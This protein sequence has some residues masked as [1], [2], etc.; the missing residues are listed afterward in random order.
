MLLQNLFIFV[1]GKYFGF[2]DSFG[3]DV[4]QQWFN[5]Y[6]PTRLDD[7]DLDESMYEV[8]SPTQSTQLDVAKVFKGKTDKKL[9]CLLTTISYFCC[10]LQ[11]VIRC[12]CSWPYFSVLTPSSYRHELSP[13]DCLE[14]S[15]P[16]LSDNWRKHVN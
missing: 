5:L 13:L 3:C 8:Y 15:C 14:I 4:L 10:C 7:T 9:V 16:W 2:Y 11:F 6:C 12:L 1:Y